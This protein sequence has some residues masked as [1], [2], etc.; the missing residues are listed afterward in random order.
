MKQELIPSS[1]N[2]YMVG[3]VNSLHMQSDLNPKKKIYPF[4]GDGV[5][6]SPTVTCEAAE[7]TAKNFRPSTV[8]RK[9]CRCFAVL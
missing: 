4:S 8:D 9:N 5:F 3:F 2:Q 7:F 6:L 1:I